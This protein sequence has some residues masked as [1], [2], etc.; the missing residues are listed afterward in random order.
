MLIIINNNN[1]WE[2]IEFVCCCFFPKYFDR[3]FS[4]EML[5]INVF[6]FVCEWF[7]LYSIWFV[8]IIYF[9]Y[10]I[11]NLNWKSWRKHFLFHFH[12]IM[13]ILI[14]CIWFLVD[15][16]HHLYLVSVDFCSD[17]YLLLSFEYNRLNR[18]VYLYFHSVEYRLNLEY[19]VFLNVFDINDMDDMCAKKMTKSLYHY[20]LSTSSE[21]I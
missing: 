12:W 6:F 5:R 15:H 18:P 16:H 11:M 2:S 7:H 21:I 20:P 17:Y 10:S 1:H 8:F 9:F 3:F 13:N 14:S 19:I 4:I